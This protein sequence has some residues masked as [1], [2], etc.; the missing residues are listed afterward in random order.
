MAID[1]AANNKRI[2]KNTLML[3]FRMLFSM[4]VSLYTSR[5]VLQVLGVEDYGIYNVVG[6]FV[7]MFSLLS[8]GLT[9]AVQRYLTYELGV[10]NIERLNKIF[11][12]SLNIFIALSIIVLL[13]T[14]SFGLWF[15]NKAMNFSIERM[16]VVNIIYQISIATF[17]VNLLSIPY[18]AA[19]ISHERF[20]AYAYIS[21]LQ[22]CLKLVV[23]LILHIIPFDKLVGYS[24]L[25]FIID[26]LIRIIYGWYCSKHFH[27]CKYRF[28]IDWRLIKEMFLFSVWSFVGSCAFLFKQQGVNIALN[29]FYGTTVNAAQGIAS[30]VSNAVSSFVSSF[31]TALNPQITKS[32]AQRDFDY[33]YSLAFRSSRYSYFLI[34]LLAMPMF[35][36]VDS[37]LKLWLNVVPPYASI[38]TQLI[39]VNT[40][41]DS[42]S[43]S[44][45][46][47]V[48][49]TGR[50]ALYQCVVG[51]I[52]LLNFPI[53]YISLF[54]EMPPYIPFIIG[55]FIALV[56]LVV[57]L[58]IMKKLIEFPIKRFIKCVLL[59]VLWVTICGIL[60][61][62]LYDSLLPTG[63]YWFLCTI[64]LSFISIAILI[65]TLGMTSYERQ[66]LFQRISSKFIKDGKK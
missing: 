17:I 49:S 47:I 1:T 60:L 46:T 18:N 14:E 64:A 42:L 44:L 26:V 59:P 43:N 55:C 38:F 51:G 57:R 24:L 58:I 39:L 40:L 8:S 41:I 9:S 54:L 28:V 50:I 22:I 63:G 62:K 25:L 20:N 32:Y 30:Q 23:V 7:A 35:L 31:T 34:F 21:I 4:L 33:M 36:R 19:I 6:G 45:I 52:L 29:I 5:V 61:A 12:V 27:E 10:G 53:S 66:I 2:A 16:T 15:V 65:L 3:Y 56:C 48:M 37:V 13:F 11:C